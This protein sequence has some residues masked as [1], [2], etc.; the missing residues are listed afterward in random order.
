MDNRWRRR[1]TWL[2]TKKIPASIG[3]LQTPKQQV[4]FTLVLFILFF[5]GFVRYQGVATNPPILNPDEASVAY[6]AFLLSKT[7][8]DEWQQSW[9]LVL[10]AFGDQ[11]IAGYTYLVVGTFW[12]AGISDLSVRL[13]AVISG[14]LLIGM[15]GILLRSVT[16]NS[17]KH[18]PVHT[19]EPSSQT[20]LLT[21]VLI[22]LQPVFIWY[23]RVGFEATPALLL[24]VILLWVLFRRSRYSLTKNNLNKKV[25]LQFLNP[26]T[27]GQVV[28]ASFLAIA[29]VFLYNV[30]LII[31]PFLVAPVIF[32]YGFSRWQAW[33]PVVLVL[34][35]VW[36]GLV[37][38]LQGLTAQKSRITLFG[39]PTYAHQQLEF[40]QSFENTFQQKVFG[41]KYVFYADLMLDR[42]LASFHTEYLF[43]N[44]GGH[45][46]HALPN[47]GYITF[48]TY[49]FGWVGVLST[50]W[51]VS[52][53]IVSV[54]SS[55]HTR[56]LDAD[57][58]ESLEE[59]SKLQSIK[60]I[61]AVYRVRLL[62]LYITVISL[63]PA[64]ITVNAPHATRT[65]LF[66]IGWCYFASLG[67]VVLFEIVRVLTAWVFQ[68]SIQIGA[69]SGRSVLYHFIVVL[70]SGL[71]AYPSGVY[72][73]T[74]LITPAN[75]HDWSADLQIWLPS[76]IA[77]IEAEDEH[78]VD[79]TEGI[80]AIKDSRVTVVD[81]RGFA[82]ILVAWYS[83]ME[84]TIFWD[85]IERYEPDTINFTYGAK[86]G[87]YEFVRSLAE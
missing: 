58:D 37:F 77:S 84:P 11:K 59:K 22:A 51:I 64:V 65:L 14:V 41:N 70:V 34:A 63:L 78:A 75:Q 44:S 30:P 17:N 29:A 81:P 32:W 33:L 10:Q 53:R 68:T 9:P 7:G 38:G 66:F 24:T 50:V 1:I 85:T 42:F 18:D 86:V 39:D 67:I 72:L 45:P 19:D 49:W 83:R 76:A 35:S 8:K 28:A 69:Y 6:N 15:V 36:I 25:G 74:L 80:D 62:F 3:F 73:H 27:I 4:V 43:Q 40:Y 2:L 82:Y 60:T 55:K 61:F 23:S 20:W 21:M 48:W 31:L 46:W 13:P 56:G 79:L 54:F 47:T 87:Q 26:G 16:R 71:I 5:G 52:K 12:A 57:F